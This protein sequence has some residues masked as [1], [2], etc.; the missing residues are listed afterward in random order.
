M[1]FHIHP[2]LWEGS[3]E[4]PPTR[5]E[6]KDKA[7]KFQLPFVVALDGRPFDAD[8]HLALHKYSAILHPHEA[9][10]AKELE[11]AT[12]ELEEATEKVNAAD[13][14]ENAQMALEEATKSKAKVEKK[15]YKPLPTYV[16]TISVTSP[17]DH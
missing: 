16:H 10:L 15:K 5:K 13:D 14:D 4:A 3:K 17:F 1:V 2:L 6:M 9:A 11:E 8:A 12:K 7:A